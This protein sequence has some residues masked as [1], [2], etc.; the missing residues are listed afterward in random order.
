MNT[1]KWKI[2]FIVVAAITALICC[3]QTPLSAQ[4]ASSIAP[5]TNTQLTAAQ[6][7]QSA[8]LYRQACNS[9]LPVL[10]L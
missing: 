9:L 7:L 5:K 8:G 6:N 2:W 4:T 3:L 1:K 10:E